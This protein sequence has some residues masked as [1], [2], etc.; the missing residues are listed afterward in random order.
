MRARLQARHMQTFATA[1]VVSL[2]LCMAGTAARAAHP[3]ISEDSGTQG[4]GNFELELGTSYAR[5]GGGRVV[6]LDPQ[7]SYGVRDDVDVILRPS[8]FWLSGTAADDAGRRRGVGTTA[9]DVKW[10]AWHGDAV[11]LGTRAGVDL[12]TASRG[13]GPHGVGLHAIA[14]ATCEARGALATANLAYTRLPDNDGDR[15]RQDLVRVSAAFVREAREGLRLAIETA[16]FQDADKT[17]QSWPAV[18]LIGAILHLPI[19]ADVDVGYQA[20]LNRAA[21]SG[22]WLAGLTLRW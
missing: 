18:V 20:R 21:P 5:D 4:G 9:L 12:P 11:S 13:L 14:V 3:L 1:C 19:G 16:V 8:V 6:E 10:R 17:V 2:V 7:L 22:V 15:V